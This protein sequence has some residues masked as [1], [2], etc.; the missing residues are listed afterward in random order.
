MVFLKHGFVL[1][2]TG[3]IG[4]KMEP[5]QELGIMDIFLQKKN[6]KNR[7]KKLIKH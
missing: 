2:G 6:K 3:K 7:R 5:E 1:G 4:R